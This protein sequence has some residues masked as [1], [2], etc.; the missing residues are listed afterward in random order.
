MKQEDL[1][2]V[3][4][5][6]DQKNIR[7][8]KE[9]MK[10]LIES[11][12]IPG[13]VFLRYLDFI[14]KSSNPESYIGDI[15]E[16]MK[17]GGPPAKK[18]TDFDISKHIKDQGMYLHKHTYIEAD[19]VYKGCC[20]YYIDNELSPFQLKEKE[21][22][23]I[24]QNVVHGIEIQGEENI[25]IKCMIP[26]EYIELEQFSEVSQE[27]EMKKFLRHATDENITKPYYIIFQL[28]ETEYVEEL[29][30][31]IFC[32]FLE[33]N[34]GWRRAEKNHLSNLF[35][36]LMR[37][38]DEELLYTK[39]A[40]EENF[41]ITKLLECIRRNYQFITLKDLAKDFHFHENYL[42]RIIK[43]HCH[44]SFRELLCQIRLKEA[45][46]LLIN[47]GLSVTEIAK[48]VGYLKPNFFFKL[49]K[50]HYHVTPIAFRNRH[51]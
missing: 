49:F 24:N 19:Y 30:Y 7:L 6:Q 38:K 17:R 18:L 44:M 16:L 10:Q 11:E 22:C 51:R 47:T 4:D 25:V 36:Y 39:E 3:I 45:E 28:L 13:S 9:N 1:L 46:K 35:L 40:E 2:K 37:I 48:R 20:T 31:H 33:K 5:Q 15:N 8:L 27:V 12:F 21:L 29:I 32:E 43:Q 26:F 42:S 41:N 50:E 34:I 23:I 14:E